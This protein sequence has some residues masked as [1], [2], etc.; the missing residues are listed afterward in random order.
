MNQAIH[1]KNH[2]VEDGGRA[3]EGNIPVVDR[4]NLS[5]A[6]NEFDTMEKTGNLCGDGHGTLDHEYTSFT[7]MLQQPDD[8]GC[9]QYHHEPMGEENRMFMITGR[10]GRDNSIDEQ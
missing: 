6:I 5:K 2:S 8:V 7:E 1:T 4:S 3:Q 9:S 10:D